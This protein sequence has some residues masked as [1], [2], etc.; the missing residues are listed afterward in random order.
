MTEY[1]SYERVNAARR[2]MQMMG[3][4]LNM[5]LFVTL[6]IIIILII[7]IITLIIII[8]LTITII[9]IIIMIII[10]IIIITVIWNII[11]CF[12]HP[13]MIILTKDVPEMI[14]VGNKSDVWQERQVVTDKACQVS[15]SMI[16]SIIL[17]M[18]KEAPIYNFN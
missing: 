10:T 2:Y 8:I 3:S 13:H 15:F 1:D 11:I 4:N 16:I 18:A 9:I 17:M 14:L 12:L 6:I 7:T 5:V